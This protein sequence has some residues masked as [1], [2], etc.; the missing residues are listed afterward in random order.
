MLLH[1]ETEAQHGRPDWLET[2]GG[3]KMKQK[4]SDLKQVQNVLLPI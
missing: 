3:R 2:K 1:I 4:F